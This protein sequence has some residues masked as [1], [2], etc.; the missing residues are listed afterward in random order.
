MQQFMQPKQ[1]P[2]DFW[3][4][5]PN[6]HRDHHDD[7]DDDDDDDIPLTDRDIH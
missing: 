3:S 4:K 1:L 6:D 7:D 5:R 2:D